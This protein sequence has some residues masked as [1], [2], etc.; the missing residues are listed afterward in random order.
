LF[1][2]ASTGVAFGID[3][4]PFGALPAPNAFRFAEK[5]TAPACLLLPLAASLAAEIAFAGTRRAAFRPVVPSILLPAVSGSL[6]AVIAMR[7][8]Q[9]LGSVAALGKTHRPLFAEALLHDLRLGL[10]D[11]ALLSVALGAAALF[12][13]ARNRPAVALAP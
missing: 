3:R 11:V 4:L 7:A 5:L 10:Q 2:L 6:A 1:A 12:R 9:L 8:P 13:G